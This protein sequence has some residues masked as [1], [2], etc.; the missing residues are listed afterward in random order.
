MSTHAVHH[1]ISTAQGRVV[2]ALAIAVTA[3]LAT[4]VVVLRGGARTASTAPP[5]RPE[6]MSLDTAVEWRALAAEWTVREIDA[7]RTVACD[8]STCEELAGRGTPAGSLLRLDGPDGPG[9]ILQSDVVIVTAQVRGTLAAQLEVLLS[10]EVLARFGTGASRFEVREVAPE[11]RAAHRVRQ[12]ADVRDRRYAGRELLAN[13]RLGVTPDVARQLSAGQVDGRLLTVIAMLSA[14]RRLYL[15]SFG[16][17]GETS[18]VPLRSVDIATVDGRPPPAAAVTGIG[19]VLRD[20]EP[21]FRPAETT[22]ATPPEGSTP[23]LRIRYGAPSP[24]G[25]LTP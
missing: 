11:G 7:G 25:L 14:D 4:G 24:L 3:L 1:W 21:R 13:R 19:R 5:S 22:L 15:R 12:A 9:T 8:P 20:Q 23:V 16:D 18:G 10:P 6:P 2:V 17:A